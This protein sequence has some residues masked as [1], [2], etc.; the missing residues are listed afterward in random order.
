M[1]QM[2]V[3]LFIVAIFVARKN[4]FII[5]LWSEMSRFFPNAALLEMLTCILH[6]YLSTDVGF[7]LA[8]AP[9]KCRAFNFIASW[10][11]SSDQVTKCENI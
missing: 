8:G 5:K 1:K 4:A 3:S 7:L 6:S 10:H 11:I 9:H 2:C